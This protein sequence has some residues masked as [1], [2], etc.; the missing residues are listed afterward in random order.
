M[1][2]AGAVGAE[3]ITLGKHILR[4]ETAGMVVLSWLGYLTEGKV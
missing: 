1:E 4:T 3:F 2:R